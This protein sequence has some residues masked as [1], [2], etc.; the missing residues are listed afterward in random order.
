MLIIYRCE[1]ILIVRVLNFMNKEKKNNF[2]KFFKYKNVYNFFYENVYFLC[3]VL[4][5]SF[6]IWYNN[7]YWE[8]NLNYLLCLWMLII[9]CNLLREKF[10]LDDR[11]KMLLCFFRRLDLL[12]KRY[13]RRLI[14]VENKCIIVFYKLRY[15]KMFL[16]FRLLYLA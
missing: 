5:K 16:F 14:R 12:D 4:I 13:F 10:I 8:S 1:R 11:W 9:K 6:W 3:I 7:M 15:V 2:I